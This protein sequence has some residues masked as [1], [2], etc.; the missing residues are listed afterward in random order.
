MFIA[1]NSYIDYAFLLD[2]Y[3]SLVDDLENLKRK[4]TDLERYFEEN[5]TNVFHAHAVKKAIQ[6]G[7]YEEAIKNRGSVADHVS[8]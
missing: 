6:E 1:P 3:S 7:K 8:D 2:H 5:I 4:K